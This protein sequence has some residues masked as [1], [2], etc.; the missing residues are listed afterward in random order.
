[1]WQDILT[2]NSVRRYQFI[3]LN[4]LGDV[5]YSNTLSRNNARAIKSANEEMF[6]DEIWASRL[7]KLDLCFCS[8]Q[9]PHDKVFVLFCLF[10][11]KYDYYCSVSDRIIP[12]LEQCFLRIKRA[13][14]DV[15]FASQFQ[16]ISVEHCFP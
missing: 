15:K 7:I 8:F 10:L 11:L 3:A 14:R 1:M 12:A 4:L 5:I 13:E 9:N 6:L 2:E 16:N